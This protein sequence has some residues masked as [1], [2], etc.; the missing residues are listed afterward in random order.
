MADR[1]QRNAQ[2][3][4]LNEDGRAYQ[5]YDCA[6]LAVLMDIREE[7]QKLNGVFS[8]PNTV[9][10]PNILRTIRANTSRI[11]TPPKIKVKVTSDSTKGASKS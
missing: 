4:V 9:E 3:P 7:L 1:R 10:I 11:P 2:W 8:C 5:N 6:I